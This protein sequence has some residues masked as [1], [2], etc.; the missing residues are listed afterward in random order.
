MTCRPTRD[1]LKQNSEPLSDLSDDEFMQIFHLRRYIVKGLIEELCPFIPNP[2][3]SDGVPATTKILITLAFYA[4]G[5]IQTLVGKSPVYNVSQATVS[6]AVRQVTEAFDKIYHK[7]VKWPS[8]RSERLLIKAKFCSK[9]KIPGVL[10]CIDGTH[11]AILKPSYNSQIYDNMKGSQSINVMIVCDSDLNI[12]CTD[13]SNPGSTHDS[14]VWENH[15]LSEQLNKF[16]DDGEQGFLLG[17]SAYPL[18]RTMMTP[19]LNTR[20]GTPEHAYYL[21]HAAAHSTIER[22]ISDLKSRFRCLLLAR[23]L[24]YSPTVAGKIVKACCILHNIANEA[25]SPVPEMTM[26][27]IR[28]EKLRTPQDLCL[29]TELEMAL[30]N[31]STS[32]ALQEG[33]EFRQTLINRLWMEP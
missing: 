11:V 16:Y 2:R 18:R 27:E 21:L 7:Y 15:P 14:T 4:S 26:E 13:A 30:E 29:S 31:S 3:R 25:N 20:E 24:H 28:T 19:I 23:S 9:F 8:Q 12:L 22:C 17:D 1:L 5:S 32:R 10:G 33:E 6:R